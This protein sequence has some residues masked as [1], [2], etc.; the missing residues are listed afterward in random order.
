MTDPDLG[1]IPTPTTED[2]DLYPGGVDAVEPT[3]PDPLPHDL[4]PQHNA[5]L[6]DKAPDEISEPDAEKE[7]APSDGAVSGETET[8]D[9]PPA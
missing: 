9:E 6:R 3:G 4:D 2:P 1:P 7:Q 5:G 8:P